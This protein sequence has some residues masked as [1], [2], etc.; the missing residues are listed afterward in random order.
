MELA[1]VARF[2][3][4]TSQETRVY[5]GCDSVV[6]SRR[7]RFWATYATVVVVHRDGCRGCKVFGRLDVQPDS[8]AMK[9]RLL[10]EAWKAGEVAA[11]LLPHLDDRQL[12]VH[13]D[14]HTNP[15][16][17]SHVAIKEAAG[18]IRGLTGLV[19]HFKPNACIASACADRYA[20]LALAV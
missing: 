4:Q 10:Q 9:P 17:G 12:E 15:E 13:L 1:E 16:G 14:I 8:G 2:I 20:R 11:E 3:G 19:A 7:G 6:R 5:V 18:Y